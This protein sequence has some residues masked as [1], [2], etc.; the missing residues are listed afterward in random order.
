MSAEYAA[1]SIA[2]AKS[3]LAVALA[4]LDD[5]AIPAAAAE[6]IISQ[7]NDVR[8]VLTELE[9]VVEKHRTGFRDGD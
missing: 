7:C 8:S 6:R 1:A 4:H 3:H 2:L 9:H 5:G